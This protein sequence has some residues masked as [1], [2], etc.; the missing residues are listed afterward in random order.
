MSRT[1]LILA[2]VAAFA[3][4]APTA[5]ADCPGALPA[6]SCPYTG[7]L[8][9]GQR[10]GGVLRFP[11]AV[12]VA[13]DGTVYVGDQGSHTVQAFGPD[14]SFRGELGAAGTR[15]GELTSVG[16]VAAASDG[17]VL[18]ADGSNRIVRFDR[19]GSLLNTWGGTGSAIGQFSFGAGGGNAAGAGGGLAV[20]GGIVYVADTG[21][22]RILRFDLQGGHGSEIVAPGALAA[23]Q[24]LAVRGTRLLVADDQHHRLAVFDTGGHPLATVGAAGAG[25]GQL[26][27]PYDVAADAQGRVFVADDLNQRVVRYSSPPSY[28][29]KARWGSYGTAPGQLAY[30][31]GIATDAQGQVYVADTGNDRIDVFDRSGNLVR[32][33]GASGRATGQFD[34]PRGVAADASGIRAV[35]DADNAR[36][37]LLNPDGSVAAVWGSPAPGPTILPEP[38]AVAFM[39][40]GDAAVLDQRRSAIVVFSRA[41]GTPAKTI[42][43]RGTG[44]GQLLA[45]SGI[46]IDASGNMYVADTGNERI[47]RFGPDGGYQGSITDAGQLRG[48]AVAPDGSRIYAADSAN[49]ITVYDGSGTELDQFGGTGSKLGKVNAPAQ[50]A[51]DGDGDLWVADRGNNRVERLG[52]NGERLFAFGARGTGDGQFIHPTAVAVDCHGTVTVTDSDNNRVQQFALAAPPAGACAQLP[53]VGN[54]PPPKLPILP[55]PAGPQLTV[56]VLRSTGLVS[57]HSLPLRVACDTGCTLTLTG[58]AQPTAKPRPTKRNKHPKPVVVSFGKLTLKLGAGDSKIL[59]PTL[60]NFA[61]GRLRKALGTRRGLTVD[62]QLTAVA[63]AGPPTSASQQLSATR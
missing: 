61:L 3:L 34:D 56:K 25:P 8:A 35:T 23:P 52:P 38:V 19:G 33:F 2:A 26:R 46:A 50:M 62:L 28:P 63:P 32:A 30:P 54:P 20:S 12:A 49:R 11:Q 5:R 22:D 36:L 53:P 7:T 24:G 43:S 15:P 55:T 44:P 10:S 51:V 57:S 18:V 13:P 41:T 40:S 9:V 1:R 29:Y 31:R 42:G 6:S 37:Q 47:A 27:N 21:N 58:T 17:S 45:P 16:A 39:P 59:R 14:G 4:L 60:S 48:I